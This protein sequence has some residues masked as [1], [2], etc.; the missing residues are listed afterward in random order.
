MSSPLTEELQI[1]VV[2]PAYREGE[3]IA[4]VVRDIKSFVPVV[5][6]VDDCSP[7]NTSEQAQL[8]GAIVVK[9]DVNRGK[10]AAL[11]TAFKKLA[12]MGC[13]YGI[14]MD[15]DGQHDPQQLPLFIKEIRDSQAIMVV[16][17]RLSNAA[18]MP[19]VRWLV[20]RSMSWLISRICR[21]S[22]PDTQCGYRALAVS[23]PSILAAKSDHFDYESEVLILTA[24]AKGVIRSV[25]V[26]TIYQ[27]EVSK[28]RPL[29][30]TIRFFKLLW[31]I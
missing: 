28:I 21:C 11:K 9:H 2:I 29:R 13:A 30:D 18:G 10:G 1:A 24:R 31:R 5:V 4:R 12:E 20:N 3:R 26:K 15:G 8:A 25:P 22:I 19:K 27:G 7:D 16:G 6:V 17:N 23:N 14:T